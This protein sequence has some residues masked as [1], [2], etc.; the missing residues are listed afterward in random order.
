MELYRLLVS[1]ISDRYSQK[2]TSSKENAEALEEMLEK[3]K[4]QNLYFEWD[5]LI[6]TPFRYPLPVNPI[7]SARFRPPYFSKNVFYGSD[8]KNTSA[9]ECSYHFLR[10]R[11]HLKNLEESGFRTLF[12]AEANV[13]GMIDIRSH[14][15]L[16]EIMDRNDYTPSFKIANE[17]ENSNGFLYTSCRSP[18]QGICAAIF[19]INC[20]DKDVKRE[21][22]VPFRYSH[23]DQCVSWSR[24]KVLDLSIRWNEVN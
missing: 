19:Q 22:N 9:Y 18:N 5:I 20:L 11:I 3:S 15:D 8:T 21:W 24:T 10:Q 12:V 4:P 7:Y 1:Q 16:A 6:A 13:Q 17:H 23:K 14:P 2:A